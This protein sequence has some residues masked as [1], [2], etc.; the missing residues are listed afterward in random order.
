MI[1]QGINLA[2]GFRYCNINLFASLLCFTT[3]YVEHVA[4]QIQESGGLVDPLHCIGTGIFFTM[5]C[6]VHICAMLLLCWAAN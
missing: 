4:C 6:P 5:V 2:P 1:I 3:D